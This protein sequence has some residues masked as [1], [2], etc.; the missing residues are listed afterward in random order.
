VP[1]DVEFATKVTHAR[2]TLT[3]AINPGVPA[4]WA[5][6]DEFYGNHRGL[7]RDLQTRNVGY[8]LAVARNHRVTRPTGS[9]ATVEHLTHQLPGRSWNRRSAGKGAK[10]ER[11]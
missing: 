2:R 10:G 9:T 7:R 6:A 5:A 3:R 4:A 8:V 11:D 1:D